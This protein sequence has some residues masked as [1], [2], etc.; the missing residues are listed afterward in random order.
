MD[1]GNMDHGDMGGMMSSEDMD[2]LANATGAEF[3]RMFLDMM[4]AH[5]SGAVQMAETEIA[6]GENPDALAMADE[7]RDTQNAEISEMQQLLAEFG[8]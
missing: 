8:G 6:D 5:H 4:T 1:H 3:D 2:S 7:I